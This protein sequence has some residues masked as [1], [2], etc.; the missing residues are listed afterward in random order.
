MLPLFAA[1]TDAGQ[2]LM[3]VALITGIVEDRGWIPASR[4]PLTRYSGSMCTQSLT[5]R[6][7]NV[8]LSTLAAF[9]HR[10]IVE[11]LTSNEILRDRTCPH[12]MVVTHALCVLG[13][14]R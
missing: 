3:V 14:S 11:E 12:R 8:D 1:G 2:R 5:I 7:G 9:V 10:F 13:D 6:L 4:N